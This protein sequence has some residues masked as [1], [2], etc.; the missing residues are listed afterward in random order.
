[1]TATSTLG[2]GFLLLYPQGGAQPVVSTLNYAPG[3]TVANA[4]IVPLGAGGLTVV[5]GVAGTDV[6]LDVNGYFEDA[7]VHDAGT[8]NIFVGPSAGKLGTTGGANTAVGF[9]ALGAS[10]GFLNTATGFFALRDNL[11]GEANTATGASA[12]VKNTTGEINTA[13][14]ALALERN[15]TGSGNVALGHEAGSNNVS[16]NDNIYIGNRGLD[17][18]ATIRIGST[19]TQTRAFVA[20]IRGVTTAGAAIPVLIDNSGQLGTISSSQRTKEAIEPMGEASRGLGR[21]RPVTFRYREATADGTRPRQYGLIA[22]EVA[23]VYPDLVAYTSDGQPET[24]LYHVLPA[25]LLNELQE[26]HRELATKTRTLE[27]QSRVLE[28]LRRRLE[29]LEGGGVAGR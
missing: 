21:L 20:G 27:T 24:V 18:S 2:P 10:D 11:L 22:E 14:G 1:V 7:M 4:A 9:Q 12:L 25:L 28:E 16:G 29:A 19:A 26:L 15:T 5:A 23:E 8:D 3:Q 17:E 6:I 13:V